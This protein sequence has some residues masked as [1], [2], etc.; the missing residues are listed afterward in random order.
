MGDLLHLEGITIDKVWTSSH[1]HT[2]TGHL[3]A[4][5]KSEEFSFSWADFIG[6]IKSKQTYSKPYY[7]KSR[8]CW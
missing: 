7:R 5:N 4:L 3:K 6:H 2:A 1:L 8:G